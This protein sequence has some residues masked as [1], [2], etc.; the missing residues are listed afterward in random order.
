MILRALRAADE[1]AVAAFTESLPA[2]ERPLRFFSGVHDERL[3]AFWADPAQG[4][5][6]YGLIG[7]TRAGAIVG[8][9]SYLR[10]YGPRAEIALNLHAS[11]ERRVAL[12]VELISE[13]ARVASENGIRH[14]V[15]ACRP[16][17]EDILG[18]FVGGAEEASRVG[19]LLV[20][21]FPIVATLARA[22][23]AGAG[24]NRPSRRGSSGAR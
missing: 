5:D 14:F 18:A 15:A 12:A 8:H 16:G 6:H 9:T 13:L 7:E 1:S 24:R 21:D 2:D 23:Q 20:V 17:N 4:T 3:A 19:D 11:V 22:A 10:L